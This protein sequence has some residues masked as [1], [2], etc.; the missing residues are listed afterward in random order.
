MRI[1]LR[2]IVKRFGNFVSLRDVDLTIEPGELVALLGPSG[3]GKTTLLRIV[4]GLEHADVG[5][6]LFDG[7]D[8]ADRNVRERG[9]GFVFQHYA[10]FRHMTVF[11]NIAFGLRVKPRVT[12][13]GE[14]EIRE[15]VHRLLELVQLEPLSQ[16]FPTQLS[17][18]QRQRVALARALAIEPQV[19][20]LDEPFGA[21][22]AKVRNELRRWLRQL[23]DDMGLTSVFVTHDQDEALELADR[24]AILNHGRIEQ[25][26][27][28][29]SLY[30]QPQTP[31][32]YGFL[33]NANRLLCHVDGGCVEV[34]GRLFPLN[35]IE[36][37]AGDGVVAFVRPHDSEIF[38]VGSNEGI[39]AAIDR[40]TAGGALVSV[41]ATL[42]RD[43]TTVEIAVSRRRFRELDLVPG[44]K[45][46]LR[47]REVA[48]FPTGSAA[49]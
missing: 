48:F 47:A 10:L 12:R 4:A 23:H 26:G 43:G 28:P 11:E 36:G 35:Q 1:E 24:V 42:E 17:G 44:Q 25:T 8:A 27:T 6:I 7:V 38:P 40:V 45:V 2:H 29:S 5:A 49:S 31:F 46:M 15:R 9:V 30:E 16:R 22:D 34:Y 21:L 41:D 37:A 18:G 14:A 39:A 20:L 19:L 32:V 3:S 13:P 33:G